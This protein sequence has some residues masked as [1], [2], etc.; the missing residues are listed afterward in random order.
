MPSPP[1]SLEA[2]AR[3]AKEQA[4]LP[5]FVLFKDKTADEI[6]KT[7][8]NAIKIFGGLPGTQ[9]VRSIAA[10]GAGI[11]FGQHGTGS[12]PAETIIILA[13]GHP[14]GNIESSSVGLPPSITDPSK[15][16]WITDA[17]RQATSVALKVGPS[18]YHV[19]SVAHAA[20][21]LRKHAQHFLA[22]V[23]LAFAG[24]SPQH[25][26]NLQT[27]WSLPGFG[28]THASWTREWWK[29]HPNPEGAVNAA[30]V[31][32]EPPQK[33]QTEQPVPDPKRQAAG[34][35]PNPPPGQPLVPP[36]QIP[37]Q[38]LPP[39]TPQNPKPPQ[40]PRT[41]PPST[42]G[43]PP[44]PPQGGDFTGCDCGGTGSHDNCGDDDARCARRELRKRI[45]QLKEELAQK[46]AEAKELET[47]WGK[48]FLRNA[49]RQMGA[50]AA[51]EK[52][53]H[54][55]QTDKSVE[56]QH[57]V[58][59]ERI[60]SLEETIQKLETEWAHTFRAP[61]GG[62]KGAD[63]K[64]PDLVQEQAYNQTIGLARAATY[65]NAYAERAVQVAAASIGEIGRAYGLDL[66]AD[67]VRTNEYV[68]LIRGILQFAVT[69][70]FATDPNVRGQ[71][72]KRVQDIL[73]SLQPIAGS[74]VVTL[75]VDDALAVFKLT[76]A[77]SRNPWNDARTQQ[78]I[79]QH[80]NLA[81]RGPDLQRVIQEVGNTP[82]SKREAFFS[83]W[84]QLLDSTSPYTRAQYGI[85]IIS[86]ALAR[87]NASL[88]AVHIY[89][90]KQ[91]LEQFARGMVTSSKTVDVLRDYMPV[92]QR[93][94]IAALQ[95]PEVALSVSAAIDDLVQS[96]A[97]TA[98]A[99]TSVQ[100]T[101]RVVSRADLS[102]LF[103]RTAPFTMVSSIDV[104]KRV[105]VAVRA[106][107]VASQAGVQTIDQFRKA[108]DAS[109]EWVDELR[110]ASDRFMT[111]AVDAPLSMGLI[112]L[113]ADS[114]NDMQALSENARIAAG[115]MLR[116]IPESDMKTAEPLVT[117][118]DKLQR[119]T[120]EVA[121]KLGGLVPDLSGG[122]FRADDV[123]PNTELGKY[124]NNVQITAAQAE[125]SIRAR[126]QTASKT[127]ESLSR[128]VETAL[129]ALVRSYEL[130]V[131]SDERRRLAAQDE[132]IRGAR[133]LVVVL[134]GL[135]G[136]LL[137][138]NAIVESAFSGQDL[139][140]ELRD[141][142]SSGAPV[143]AP[144]LLRLIGTVDAAARVA[145]AY[146]IQKGGVA[147]LAAIDAP[148]GGAV[149]TALKTAAN[150]PYGL[151]GVFGRQSVN[152]IQFMRVLLRRWDKF[153]LLAVRAIDAGLEDFVIDQNKVGGSTADY[154]YR[155]AGSPG[156]SNA[157]RPCPDEDPTHFNKKA[158]VKD[159]IKSMT[160]E[161]IKLAKELSEWH[162]RFWSMLDD[163][164]GLDF[165]SG[166]PTVDATDVS[167]SDSYSIRRT[168]DL[169]IMRRVLANDVGPNYVQRE[170]YEQQHLGPFARINDSAVT[171]A[172][173]QAIARAVRSALNRFLPMANRI[174]GREDLQLNTVLDGVD[175]A[176]TDLRRTLE[177]EAKTRVENSRRLLE[178]TARYCADRLVELQARLAVADP[179]VSAPASVG[180]HLYRVAYEMDVGFA[181]ALSGLSE[182][183]SSAVGKILRGALKQ[184]FVRFL[185]PE[186]AMRGARQALQKVRPGIVATDMDARTLM[187]ALVA[188]TS[189][190]AVAARGGRGDGAAGA[191]VSGGSG[192]PSDTRDTWL[193]R[194]AE[195]LSAAI[196]VLGEDNISVI[197]ADL[198]VIIDGQL[199]LRVKDPQG[200]AGP[201]DPSA[202][203]IAD[204]ERQERLRVYNLAQGIVS[205]VL[206]N[207]PGVA[208]ERVWS[209]LRTICIARFVGATQAT[210]EYLASAGRHIGTT[211]HLDSIHVKNPTLFRTDKRRTTHAEIFKCALKNE[212]SRVSFG[213]FVGVQMRADTMHRVVRSKELHVVE[214]KARL[215]R[216]GQQYARTVLE[217]YASEAS[218][219]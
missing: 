60:K 161:Q 82:Q 201:V 143:G 21:G 134:S 155:G 162:Q 101:H 173:R 75:T 52:E 144:K 12:S 141:G 90:E 102:S 156:A 209:A 95:Q 195:F 198:F 163:R 22:C 130:E 92:R 184:E 214:D 120:R 19:E 115:A 45:D 174:V 73:T 78:F 96:L 49:S 122:I 123:P 126:A 204:Q 146:A 27:F 203:F 172:G 80:P 61:A 170:V 86:D 11:A 4:T 206:V 29:E 217:W 5:W 26:R 56:R 87:V 158:L 192:M 196:A 175:A 34:Q 64:I 51:E 216:L 65:V 112:K 116:L 103:A 131:T 66:Y 139:G 6:N 152:Y 176:A 84:S 28:T 23:V 125:A 135:V 157:Y 16:K 71:A 9:D 43:P 190:A 33:R 30:V 121:D 58:L 167:I 207:S 151:A 100:T 104:V 3:K 39:Q 37:K 106:C 62:R 168:Y 211:G 76:V 88:S 199:T 153:A 99:A 182:G 32:R 202:G 177:G 40:P 164:Q 13:N 72:A 105:L 171:A 69:R 1:A 68:T 38:P 18:T 97:R 70:D 119:K 213:Q 140:V 77:A 205:D 180:Y 57:A 41:P 24:E 149:Q 129:R 133:A 160:F 36:P 218:W 109:R 54:D 118:H 48:R 169:A 50:K 137:N 59:K 145:M 148:A 113:L 208:A 127:A 147:G 189:D 181:S 186:N 194:I 44:P 150:P 2:V 85:N 46:Q 15:A 42:G 200:A 47:R 193:G 187:E 79:V 83:A 14:R 10:A 94:A 219:Q 20:H 67:S 185:V 138:Q 111:K 154:V 81:S 197:N 178:L 136:R 188:A 212:G 7:L 183:E 114:M 25:L 132:A 215:A 98:L 108:R 31:A 110:S 159:D 179:N 53:D 91:D 128:E 210:L 142:S 124:I 165:F 166:A 74:P 35:S 89:H 191:R 17:M 93:A 107:V 117:A 8:G 63:S 55:I